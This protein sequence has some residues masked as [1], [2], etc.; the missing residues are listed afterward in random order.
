MPCVC[1]FTRSGWVLV[2]S[3]GTPHSLALLL[4]TLAVLSLTV[5]Q[6]HKACIC[7]CGFIWICTAREV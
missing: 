6:M 4:Q 5:L 2:R 3:W 1:E 7:R